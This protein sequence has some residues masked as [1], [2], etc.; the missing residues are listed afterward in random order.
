MD[1]ETERAGLC[2]FLDMQREAL[3]DDDDADD[4]GQLPARERT[5]GLCVHENSPSLDRTRG[6]VAVNRYE[7]GLGTVPGATTY[8]YALAYMVALAAERAHRTLP[9]GTT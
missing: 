8:P 7:G 9:G 2:Q 4:R 1:A 5:P 6:S 3:I